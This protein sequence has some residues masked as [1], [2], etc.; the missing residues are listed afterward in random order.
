MIEYGEMVSS[1]PRFTPSRLNWTPETPT[2]SEAVADTV[3]VPDTV[4][5]PVGEVIETVGGV[6]SPPGQAE[7]V[8]PVLPDTLVELAPAYQLAP[9]VAVESCKEI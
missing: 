7:N 5:P 8:Q 1:A 4:D 9:P 6:E 3:V 2:L